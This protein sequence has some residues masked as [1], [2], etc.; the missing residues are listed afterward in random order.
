MAPKRGR[1]GSK[2]VEHEINHDEEWVRSIS[3]EAMLNNLV[4]Y[5]VLP[6]R[7]MAGWWPV[8]GEDFLTPRIDELVMFED[9]F[10]HGFG[11]PIHPFL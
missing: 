5:G 2:K 1:G 6:D 8:A 3:D 7:A 11:V 9:Y 10:F 4:E